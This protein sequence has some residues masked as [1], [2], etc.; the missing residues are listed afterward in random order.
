VALRSKES[1]SSTTTSTTTTTT[2]TST[3]AAP[4]MSGVLPYSSRSWI[5]LRINTRDSLKEFTAEILMYL[6]IVAAVPVTYGINS[7]DHFLKEFTHSGGTSYV[8]LMYL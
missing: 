5:Y 1:V 2:S 4:I 7:R 6:L 3:W 8:I